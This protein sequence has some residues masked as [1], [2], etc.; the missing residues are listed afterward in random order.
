M[1]PKTAPTDRPR[2]RDRFFWCLVVFAVAASVRWLHLW[3]LQGS[4]LLEFLIGDNQEVTFNTLEPTSQFAAY[5][6]DF[7]WDIEKAELPISR[8]VYAVRLK[9]TSRRSCCGGSAKTIAPLV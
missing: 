5:H 7:L 4:P 9:S 2:G 8:T 1:T 6:F 3:Q